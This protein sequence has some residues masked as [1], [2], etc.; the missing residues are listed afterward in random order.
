MEMNA[1][2]R[3]MSQGADDMAELLDS[4]PLARRV[5][6]GLA[7]AI[8]FSAVGLPSS[9]T[10][11]VTDRYIVLLDV[12]PAYV[13]TILEGHSRAL[14][15]A[16]ATIYQHAIAGYA[17][18]LDA[19]Q[20]AALQVDPLVSAIGKDASMTVTGQTIPTGVDRIDTDRNTRANIDQVDERIDADIAVIDTGV[21][22][23]PD[24]NV[25]SRMDCT[26]PNACTEVPPSRWNEHDRGGH[27]TA[28]A[29]V[30]AAID[31]DTGFV[32]VAPGARLYSLK[33]GTNK[34]SIS[35]II[36]ALDWVFLHADT[37]DIV[38][39]SFGTKREP[40]NSVVLDAMHL[41]VQ[42][43]MRRGVA[44]TV[45]AGNDSADVY[46]GDGPG[47][48][49]FEP[50]A[51]PE[52]LTVS[53]LDDADGKSGGD[54]FAS[55]SNYGAAVDMIA[56]GVNLESTPLPM[57]GGEFVPT[58]NGT[59]FSAPHA[60]GVIALYIAENGR[61]TDAAGVERIYE[62][63]I[64]AGQPQDGPHGISGDPDGFPEPVVWATGP[65]FGNTRP[66]ASFDYA[67]RDLTCTFTSAST[68]DDGRIAEER[69][70][71]GD[72][73]TGTGSVVEHAFPSAGSYAVS[74]AVTDDEGASSFATQT[75]EVTEGQRKN[76]PPSADFT[77]VCS[78]ATCS[79]TDAS[80]DSDGAIAAWQWSF[81]DD[82]GDDV[83][84]ATHRY[85][86]AG[87][88]TVTLTV[89]DDEGATASIAR[90]VTVTAPVIE[91]SASGYKMQGVKHV[92]LSWA[93][94]SGA[95]IVIYRDGIQIAVTGN[96]GAFTD[97]LGER[98][99]VRS[100]SYQICEVSSSFCSSIVTV[101]V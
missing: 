10:A 90:A 8:V 43:V 7:V 59:S 47:G 9:A 97:T 4:R 73:M 66:N 86:A 35:A 92:N 91:L 11:S 18:D 67:C 49:D 33:V 25:V 34:L 12:A 27:G 52:V 79:F 41:A 48:N 63:V 50:A 84:N 16:P 46:G 45:S 29:G 65:V 40:L 24:L 54:G 36:L 42:N 39:M 53:A 21:A 100:I 83:Q 30:A 72:G 76:M 55:F 85:T 96:D 62:A 57:Y 95:S 98:G 68:D 3:P 5:R 17:A 78:D 14:K 31:N 2:K 87:E 23:S 56:P 22:P 15:F 70:D 82:T 28:V 38:N 6:L 101:E 37:I 75:V 58:W 64:A 77:S 89:T 80:S 51:Y 88:Y 94:A 19:A 32:G 74:V 20:V 99:R 1:F 13:Q 69:W 61:A 26:E 81:G 60:A 93:G 44:M 71:F